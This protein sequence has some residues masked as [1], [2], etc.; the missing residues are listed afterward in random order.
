M[1]AVTSYKL[2]KLTYMCPQDMNDD[3]SDDDDDDDGDVYGISGVIP[4]GSDR[5]G[6]KSVQNYLLEKATGGKVSARSIQRC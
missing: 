5:E 4:L 2:T 6:A 3:D 1:A